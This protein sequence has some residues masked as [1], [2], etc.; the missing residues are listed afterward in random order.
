MKTISLL[1]FYITFTGSLAAQND[2]DTIS[3][4]P[5]QVSFIHPIGLYGTTSQTQKNFLSFNIFYGVNGGLLGFEFGG[6]AN[7]NLGD[8]NGCQIAGIAN[9]NLA[10]ANGVLIAGI[11][12]FVA[13][14]AY[15]IAI[16]GLSNRFGKISGGMQI[17]GLANTVDGGYTGMQIAG[18]RNKTNGPFL[19]LQIAGLSNF[20][21]GHF[22]GLQISAISNINTG[23]LQGIQVGLINRAQK[24]GG[25]QVGLINFA[26]EYE[27][28]T[29]I[30]LLSIV[31]DG[32]NTLD[33]SYNESVNYNANLKL[34][35][36]HFY[37]IFK[38]GYMP[39]PKGEYFSYGLGVGSM[40]NL[41]NRFKISVD[42]SASYISEKKFTPTIDFLTEGQLSLR[43]N[44]LENIGL[45]A[46]PSFNAYFG[47][48]DSEGNTLLYVPKPIY[49]EKWWGNQGITKLWLGYNL[50]VSVM[51]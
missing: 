11:S 27:F 8:V 10:S 30:G 4:K 38:F 29:P 51:F 6:I 5:I 26:N 49:D 50:G 21:S 31:K 33:L 18:L 32:F 2:S 9:N 12:N 20:N 13:D 46:G 7:K 28:G 44:I 36:D 1:L 34:G 37:N 17:A 48:Y 43:Y 23:N 35:V 42:L 16:A 45:F 15:C 40:V 14:S 19:G 24:V 22:N 39:K 25:L 3:T 41:T 47:E